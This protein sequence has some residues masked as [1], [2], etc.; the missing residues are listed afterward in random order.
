MPLFMRLFLGV[1]GRVAV[2]AL[3]GMVLSSLILAFLRING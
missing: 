2:Y 3:H 1:F